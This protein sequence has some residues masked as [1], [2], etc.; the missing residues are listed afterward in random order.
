MTTRLPLNS[1][2]WG[3]SDCINLSK[4]R[5]DELRAE[6]KGTSPHQSFFK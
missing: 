2:S 3:K 1:G 6:G 4:K 5:I